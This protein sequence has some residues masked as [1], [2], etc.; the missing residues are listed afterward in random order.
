[1]S[2]LPI[3]FSLHTL[4]ATFQFPLFKIGIPNWVE[5]IGFTLHLDVALNRNSQ[6]VQCKDSFFPLTSYSKPKIQFLF[7]FLM[8]N[9]PY[10]PSSWLVGVSSVW[11]T[12]QMVNQ[13]HGQ[14]CWIL[15]FIPH[16]IL[17]TF[18]HELFKT[19]QNSVTWSRTSIAKSLPA[20]FHF[21]IFFL[22]SRSY[23]K[24]YCFIRLETVNFS[25]GK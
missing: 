14:A 12:F 22:Y 23:I 4:T 13:K 8:K 24:T 18:I 1:M 17:P 16:G 11:P 10:Y 2:S 5:Q 15:S 6:P 25:L 20:S 21:P 7:P 9:L 3:K 19:I